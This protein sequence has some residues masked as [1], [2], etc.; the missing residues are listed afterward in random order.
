MYREK[1]VGCKGG[2]ADEGKEG[3]LPPSNDTTEPTNTMIFYPT[4]VSTQKEIAGGRVADIDTRQGD[5]DGTASPVIPIGDCKCGQDIS[6]DLIK[7]KNDNTKQLN[8]PWMVHFRI[9]LENKEH[10]E[11]SG[12]LINR[13]WIISAAHCFCPLHEV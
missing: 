1:C 5:G 12:S 7:S 10:I 11:C 8:R 3:T 9:Q 6:R 2:Q 4:D 13:R